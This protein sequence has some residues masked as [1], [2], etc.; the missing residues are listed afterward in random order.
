MTT[1]PV[2]SYMKV[3]FQATTKI[4]TLQRRALQYYKVEAYRINYEEDA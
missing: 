4:P 3:Q 1:N 2:N